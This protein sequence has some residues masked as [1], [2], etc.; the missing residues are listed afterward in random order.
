MVVSPN[1]LIYNCRKHCPS[2]GPLHLQNL[3]RFTQDFSKIGKNPAPMAKLTLG[4]SPQALIS[5]RSSEGE[6]RD[7]DLPSQH[8]PRRQ[9][10]P[11][12]PQRGLEA[13]DDF[14]PFNVLSDRRYCQC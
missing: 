1:I 11:Q 4:S 2:Q 14:T 3:T 9:R 13:R 5:P 12:H 6:V 7:Q 10:L 8:R